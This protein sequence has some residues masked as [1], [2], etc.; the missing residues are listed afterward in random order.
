ML[1]TTLKSL[2]TVNTELAAA[3]EEKVP[4]KM[5]SVPP[6]LESVELKVAAGAPPVWELVAN[7]QEPTKVRARAEAGS[8]STTAA[9]N[10]VLR[11]IPLPMSP[12]IESPPLDGRNLGALSHGEAGGGK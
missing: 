8:N 1:S 10:V 4:M 11:T 5:E 6:V 2:C 12:D 3:L 7:D 9:T